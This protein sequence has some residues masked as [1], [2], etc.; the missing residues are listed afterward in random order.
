MTAT[1]TTAAT[2][3]RRGAPRL[4]ALLAS[5]W[6][7]AL[8]RRS[9]RWLVLL[10]VVAVVGIGALLLLTTAR[11]S[12]GD[13]DRAAAQYLAEQQMYYDDCVSSAGQAANLE[14]I[15]YRPSE[16]D[17]RANALWMLDRRPFDD[18]SMSGLVGFAGGLGAVICLMLGATSGGA[19]WGARTM[20]LLL[21]WEPRR[22][23]VLLV[24]LSV[25]VVL[26]LVAQALLVAVGVGIGAAIAAVH[27]MDPALSQVVDPMASAPVDLG[28]AAG[29]AVRWLAVGLLAGAAG[30]GVAMA[31]RST[32]WALGASA[33]FM[34]VVESLVQALWPWG[35]QWLVQT[36]TF[37]WLQGGLEVTVRRVAASGGPYDALPGTIWLS[38][39][40]ALATLGAMVLAVLVV[41][42]ILLRTRDVD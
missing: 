36:N 35:S 17:A 3:A 4:S 21:S 32:G 30:Y 37:A 18:S 20:G 22:L 19:D 9:V 24:R 15:C 39:G 23:R 28:D 38:E 2:Q 5:E 26:A 31:T 7:R 10:G 8:S 29:F 33:G 42:G 34:L 40:R 41:A 12:P 16:E 6:T 27:G 25:V 1:T 14:E 13:L 11:V